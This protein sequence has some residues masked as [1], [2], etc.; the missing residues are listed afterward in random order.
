MSFLIESEYTN[1]SED[2]LG[3]YV[4]NFNLL[5]KKY[6][7]VKELE[8]T[9]KYVEYKDGNI[10]VKSELMQLPY[11]TIALSLI[12]YI[13][14]LSSGYYSEINAHGLDDLKSK[15][16][17]E[18]GE[19]YREVFGDYYFLCGPRATTVTNIT[20]GMGIFSSVPDAEQLGLPNQDT[21]GIPYVDRFAGLDFNWLLGK[22][23]ETLNEVDYIDNNLQFTVK[24][25]YGIVITY[26]NGIVNFEVYNRDSVNGTDY[27]VGFSRN[28]RESQ[29]Q[30]DNKME[31]NPN[32]QYKSIRPIV[33]TEKD[34][35]INS[36]WF[37]LVKNWVN[38]YSLTKRA[39]FKTPERRYMYHNI[40]MPGDSEI[41]ERRFTDIDIYLDISKSMRDKTLSKALILLDNSIFKD[42]KLNYFTF[43]D[44]LTNL[45]GKK[46]N[47]TNIY[48]HNSTNIKAV[49][50][51]IIKRSNKKN[52]LTMIISDG[53]FD[54]DEIS[55]LGDSPVIILS[56][57]KVEGICSKNIC[58]VI[59]V[60]E[61]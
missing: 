18:I 52:R 29:N 53:K 57:K 14:K 42:Y 5:G 27:D 49:V 43:G 56:D 31:L 61:P 16:L 60:T 8:N 37:Y 19:T 13:N 41:I 33:Y 32:I 35:L 26:N 51:E 39:S 40:I 2:F 36:N 12:L 9:E 11:H 58:N 17:R 48:S 4:Y 46:I 55:R 3:F 45:K 44:Y 22:I 10:I 21:S 30:I 25:S 24:V 47:P 34:K 1:P 38:Q 59:I 23:K 20:R 54:K 7:D 28:C 15:A 6:I 50:D